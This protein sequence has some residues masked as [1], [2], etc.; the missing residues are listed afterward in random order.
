MRV[1]FFP[2]LSSVNV[3]DG[4]HCDGISAIDDVRTPGIQGRSNRWPALVT[5]TGHMGH[6]HDGPHHGRE[7]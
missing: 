2:F 4:V 7:V 3:F 6:D 5:R 1:F